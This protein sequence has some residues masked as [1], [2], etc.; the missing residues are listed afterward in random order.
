[1]TK[2]LFDAYLMVDWSAST[3]PTKPGAGN[4]IWIAFC[5]PDGAGMAEEN[6]RTRADAM[7]HLARYMT[8]LLA[9][10]ARVLAGFDFAFG[11]PAG[12]ARF[13]TGYDDWAAVW[14][15]L[16]ERIEDAGD[17]RNNRFDVADR[18]NREAFPN[19]V[20]WGRPKERTDLRSLPARR[21]VD[22]SAVPEKR[23]AERLLPRTQP[24]WKVAYNGSVGSQ[25]MTGM[26]R[27]EAL[28]RRDLGGRIAVWPFETNFEHGL[29]VGPSVTLL[30]IYPSAFSVER[31]GEE[32][33]DRAQV[34]TVAGVAAGL[35]AEGR[36]PEFLSAPP[37]TS[38][39]DRRIMLTEEGSI[40]GAG[41]V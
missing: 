28:R 10:G 37:G 26:A 36:L 5:G 33:I 7:A 21:E 25:A 41:R 34:R 4:S 27:L 32:V 23:Y 19:P 11:Y 12:A 31:R 29:P 30:E 1:M 24:V 18:L 39:E 35:D 13:M 6:F 17:N 20:F 14:A 15:M 40:F 16:H 8:D 38:E 3:S 2:R 9:A 22:Y